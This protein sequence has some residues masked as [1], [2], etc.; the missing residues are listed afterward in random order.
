MKMSKKLAN[1][2]S[3]IS[4]DKQLEDYRQ[5]KSIRDRLTTSNSKRK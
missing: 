4:K 2:R 3:F 5:D 1:T